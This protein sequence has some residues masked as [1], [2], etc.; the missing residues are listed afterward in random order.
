MKT[1]Q[2]AQ[3][4]YPHEYKQENTKYGADMRKKAG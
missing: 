1:S 2:V 4:I 3:E